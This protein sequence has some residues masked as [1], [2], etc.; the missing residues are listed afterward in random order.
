M[1]RQRLPNR[2]FADTIEFEH[3]T[4][5]S[6]LH[7]VATVGHFEDGTVAE[8]FLN[9]NKQGTFSDTNA[10]DAAIAASL[11]LQYGCPVTTL[12]KA[13]TRNADGSPAGPLGHLLDIVEEK[14]SE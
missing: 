9:A 14:P 11:A 4:G 3:D 8:I 13:L 1:T 12:R 5:T 7:Y 2:R 6:T 10:R